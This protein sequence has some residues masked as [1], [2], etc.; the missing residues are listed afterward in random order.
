MSRVA[1][2]RQSVEDYRTAELITSA[3]QDISATEMQDLRS[4][5]E[6]NATFFEGIRE[7]YA[8]VKAHAREMLGHDNEP[9]AKHRKR[10][11]YIALTSNRRFFGT[12]NRDIIRA[13][14]R[15]IESAADSDFLVIGQT[16]G[17]YLEA[18]QYRERVSRAEFEDDAP[19]DS[20]R[21]DV[22][23]LIDAYARV[24]IVY[25]KFINP[26]RQDVAMTDIT[27]APT[28]A[29][30]P[31]ARAEYIFEPELANMLGFFERQ[32]RRTLFERVLLETELAR[33]AARTMKMRNARD[34]AGELR[35]KEERR[36]RHEY[37]MLAD[38]ALMESFIGF[39][40]WKRK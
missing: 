38:I 10:D 7:V 32:V 24:F 26:F 14:E 12:M 40:L 16:G 17:Q 23:S 22:I 15:T 3:L 4:R 39:S 13:F 34:R 20:E 27:Q 30:S 29:V 31:E 1:E 19:S 25:P 28:G 18:S 21:E 33:D 36:L 9:K 6:R 37:A 35:E 5:F 8:I 11:I 2:I